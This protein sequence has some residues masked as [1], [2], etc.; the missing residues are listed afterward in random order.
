VG[1]LHALLAD[2]APEP[3]QQ[4]VVGIETDRGLLVSVLLAAGY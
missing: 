3:K 1:Q 4:V 2:H